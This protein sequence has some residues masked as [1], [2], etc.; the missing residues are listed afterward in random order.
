ML[1]LI[2]IKPE[3]AEIL[4]KWRSEP[5]MV[6]YNPVSPVALENMRYQ[7]EMMSSDLSNL[8]SAEEFRFFMQC[9]NQLVGTIGLKNINH[10]MLFGEIGYGVGEAFH[11][12]GFGTAGLKLFAEKIFAETSLRRII[13]YVAE[14]N[15]ASRR[16]LEKV[17]FIQ[18]GILREHYLIQGK[19]VNEV[20]YG[21]LRSD[22]EK[23]FS[24]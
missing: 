9:K 23:T 4:L 17:G 1:K 7:M 6:R 13:A 21:F 16:I 18:E 5:D 19:P 14:G 22:W 8:N 2:P 20:L 10:R 3:Y 15:S 11:G 12:K 24:K